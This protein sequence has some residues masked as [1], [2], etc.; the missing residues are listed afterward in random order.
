MNDRE[1]LR[2]D[3]SLSDTEKLDQ[4]LNKW[5]RNETK[6]V[7]WRIMLEALKS[8]GR[9]DLIRKVISYLQKPENY[10]KFISMN[11]YTR[12]TF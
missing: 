8:L 9:Q 4:I 1:T 7:K 6:P 3:F 10:Q 2:R 12:I 5:C 11:N